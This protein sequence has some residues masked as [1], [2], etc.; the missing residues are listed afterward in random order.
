M[1]K[2]S[3]AAGSPVPVWNGLEQGIIT[4]RATPGNGVLFA[5]SVTPWVAGAPSP[6]LA[7]GNSADAPSAPTVNPRIDLLLDNNTWISGSEAAQPVAPSVTAGRAWLLQVYRRVS[8][9]VIADDDN[10]VDAF[11]CGINT[12]YSS[13]FWRLGTGTSQNIAGSAFVEVTRSYLPVLME[14]AGPLFEGMSIVFRNSTGANCEVY[15]KTDGVLRQGGEAPAVAGAG[16]TES[17]G[18]VIPGRQKNTG[19]VQIV[20]VIRCSP[21]NADFILP[22]VWARFPKA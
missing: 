19:T 17:I 11:I 16:S 10:D 2:Y 8:N 12:I 4:Q 5:G 7:N 20:T 22:I 1:A 21:G 18:F 9:S 14:R 13:E 6:L 15:L 3:G